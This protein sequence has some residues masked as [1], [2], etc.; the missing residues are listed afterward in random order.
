MSPTSGRRSPSEA[1]LT[2]MGCGMAFPNRSGRR[3][4]W[5]PFDDRMLNYYGRCRLRRQVS[6]VPGY[7]V[8]VAADAWTIIV[9]GARALDLGPQRL[10][11]ASARIGS[12]CSSTRPSGRSCA[13]CHAGG[14]SRRRGPSRPRVVEAKGNGP[15]TRVHPCG[16]PS[17][18][19]G[20]CRRASPRAGTGWSI[21]P[22]ETVPCGC[23]VCY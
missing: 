2:P 15:G 13:G 12:P 20:A 4:P 14:R 10:A 3:A 11:P 17:R 9:L 19:A 1:L 8:V 22:G 6:G 5:G 18:V 21:H 23:A 16:A 7:R